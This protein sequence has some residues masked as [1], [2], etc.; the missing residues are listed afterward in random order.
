MAAA[1]VPAG[2][3]R[4]NC[5]KAKKKA[6]SQRRL[7]WYAVGLSHGG[8]SGP[9]Y[10]WMLVYCVKRW[11]RQRKFIQKATKSRVFLSERHSSFA[12]SPIYTTWRKLT[13]Q[14]PDRSGT[15]LSTARIS[16][17]DSGPREVKK[18]GVEKGTEETA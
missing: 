13:P 14:L 12:L 18:A 1:A 15:K 10:V 4:T 2:K 5:Q 8:P 16:V 3:G 6:T 7:A 17:E 11:Y 9:R